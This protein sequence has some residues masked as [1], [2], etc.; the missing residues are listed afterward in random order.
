MDMLPHP[1]LPP[2]IPHTPLPLR[3]CKW[4]DKKT[5]SCF[6]I[7]GRGSINLQQTAGHRPAPL[8]ECQP[9]GWLPAQSSGR[10]LGTQ[11]TWG[12]LPGSQLAK[13]ALSRDDPSGSGRRGAWPGPLP[14]NQTEHRAGPSLGVHRE[15]LAEILFCPVFVF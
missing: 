13:V 10:A 11:P 15:K 8:P 6:P 7:A 2:P 5:K 1:S 14:A 9:L 4:D 12:S 3:K